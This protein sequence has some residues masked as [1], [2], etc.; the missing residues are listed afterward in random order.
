MVVMMD[1]FIIDK[2][3]NNE[4]ECSLSNKFEFSIK[5]N[6]FLGS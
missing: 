4:S 2:F 1:S 5:N 3:L 6:P